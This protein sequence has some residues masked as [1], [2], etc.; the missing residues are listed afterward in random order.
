M[1]VIERSSTTRRQKKQPIKKQKPKFCFADFNLKD[2]TNLSPLQLARIESMYNRIIKTKLEAFRFD[3]FEMEVIEMMIK[4]G[5]WEIS[6]PP[7]ELAGFNG[8]PNE[9]VM[10]LSFSAE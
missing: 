10:P 3:K 7:I 9:Y 5:M 1:L 4:L 2:G 8:D 6:H